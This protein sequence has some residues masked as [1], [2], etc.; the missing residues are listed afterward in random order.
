M[1]AAGRNLGR[2]PITV[3]LVDG[4]AMFRRGLAGVLAGYGG[5]E[6][7]AEVPNDADAT[8]LAREP[9]P[10]AVVMQVQMHELLGRP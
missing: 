6:V 2:K 5:M 7:V 10:D 9:K 3:L 4:H 1:P 8:R